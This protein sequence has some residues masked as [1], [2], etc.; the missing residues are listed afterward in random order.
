MFKDYHR[1]KIFASRMEAMLTLGML[2]NID[3]SSWTHT[4]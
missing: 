4:V 3:K 1:E 2:G